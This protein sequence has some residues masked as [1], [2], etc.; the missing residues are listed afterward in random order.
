[1]SL[2]TRTA[3]Y[4]G[5]VGVVSKL[6]VDASANENFVPF[7]RDT[8]SFSVTVITNLGS[9]PCCLLG[10]YYMRWVWRG[11]LCHSSIDYPHL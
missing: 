3:L 11:L 4:A 1:M 6:R 2:V 7:C 9:F 10:I 5:S 8:A